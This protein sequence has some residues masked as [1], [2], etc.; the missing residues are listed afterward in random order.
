MYNRIEY[1][2]FNLK[3]LSVL[4][5][6]ENIWGGK[7]NSTIKCIYVLCRQSGMYLLHLVLKHTVYLKEGLDEWALDPTNSNLCH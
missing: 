4:T 6:N 1:E 5:E 3:N 7:C 2:N